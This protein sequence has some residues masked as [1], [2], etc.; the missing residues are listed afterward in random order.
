MHFVYLGL[1]RCYR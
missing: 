1:G